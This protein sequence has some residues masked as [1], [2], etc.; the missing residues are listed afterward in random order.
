M[1]APVRFLFVAVAGWVV[2]R[3]SHRSPR[4]RPRRRRSSRRSFRP[5]RPSSRSLRSSPNMPP[6]LATPI[7]R[8]RRLTQ[9]IPR[10]PAIFR[11]RSIITRRPQLPELRL[12]CRRLRKR[13][14][15]MKRRNS[16]RPFR[17]SISGTW[18]RSL[19][20]PFPDRPARAHRL[21]RDFRPS[22]RKSI[23][24]GFSSAPGLCGGG[25][26]RHGLAGERWDARG[27][28][29]R[30]TSD[31]CNRPADCGVASVERADRWKP[32]GRSCCGRQAD[33]FPVDPGVGHCRA[34]TG[35]REIQHR[36]LGFR[37]LRG[38][39]GLPAAT[40]LGSVPRRLRARPV[41]GRFS[42]GLGVWGGYQPGL[43]R[44]DAGPR[45][46]MRVRS[47]VSVHFDWRQRLA[48]TAE[49][50]SGPAVT[51]GANF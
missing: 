7:T 20:A 35:D 14:R 25:R 13:S 44:V 21:P 6:I 16:T 46:S 42:A 37:F 50:G 39:R 29:G 8:R 32:R 12:R 27:Q 22:F 18:R 5:S 9:D 40:R 26:L 43:Y 38:R 47:N 10:R 36:P 15:P 3:G 51:L 1:S 34:Q 33:A 2:L 48:G 49:P 30:W 11:R 31:L 41:W 19:A 28:P 17:N 4:P 23:S 24:T 45:I